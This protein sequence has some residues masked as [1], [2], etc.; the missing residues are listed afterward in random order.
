MFEIDD[1]SLPW[2]FERTFDLIHARMVFC[3]FPD[4][5]HI[6][7]EAFKALAAGGVLEMQDV[8]FDFRSPDNSLKDSAIE[9]W[10]E[11]LKKAFESRGIDLTCVL[12]YKDYLE[13]A[14]FENIQQEEF[15]WPVGTWLKGK[16]LEN[17]GRWCQANILDMLHAISIVPLTEYGP[18]SMS[19]E[20]VYLLLADVRKE[21]C[22]T[23]IHTY[24]EV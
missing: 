3:C 9:K 5:L 24:L 8:I 18:Q 1:L 7:K 10:M 15:L 20:A 12:R 2:T 17:L 6:F 14:G 23:S 21:L 22:D 16:N 11:K 13:A 19:E 4:P